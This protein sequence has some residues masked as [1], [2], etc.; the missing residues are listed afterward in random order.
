MT[1][2][3]RLVAERIGGLAAVQAFCR[4]QPI[5]RLALFGSVLRDDFRPDSDVDVLVEYEPDASVT[6]FD[7][8]RQEDELSR[9]IGQPVDLRTPQEISRHFRKKVLR[10]AWVIYERAG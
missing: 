7:M 6:F 9:I 2:P 4:R 1:A 5:R 8:V 3:D 10:E